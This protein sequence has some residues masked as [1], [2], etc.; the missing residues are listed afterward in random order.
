[1]NLIWA[2]SASQT[3][4]DTLTCPLLLTHMEISSQEKLQLWGVGSANDNRL[5]YNQYIGIT[6]LQDMR[7][8][9]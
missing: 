7:T 2:T 6:Y 3:L 4:D 8:L 9:F 5:M 1:M